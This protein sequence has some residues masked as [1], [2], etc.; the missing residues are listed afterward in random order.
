MTSLA[1]NNWA[2]VCQQFMMNEVTVQIDPKI[3]LRL[4]QRLQKAFSDQFATHPAV[5]GTP[6]GSKMDL[7]KF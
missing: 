6:T 5:S 4:E 3:N 2:L 1:L 7:L